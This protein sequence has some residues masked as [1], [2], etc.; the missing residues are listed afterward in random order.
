MYPGNARC[1]KY[2][3]FQRNLERKG[4][5]Q[6]TN[7]QAVWS[8]GFWNKIEGDSKVGDKLLE[9][10]G[11]SIWQK[12]EGVLRVEK[13]SEVR[14]VGHRKEVPGQQRKI[15]YGKKRRVE[16]T[17]GEGGSTDIKSKNLKVDFR[18]DRT[19]GGK[20]PILSVMEKGSKHWDF[21]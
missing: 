14:R 9:V 8:V 7:D 2:G 21:P 17:G 10:V 5:N 19:R 16:G 6:V 11:K 3:S 18:K 4:Y 15:H 20:G 12:N 13:D 1:I